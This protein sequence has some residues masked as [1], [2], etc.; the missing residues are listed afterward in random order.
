[1]STTVKEMKAHLWQVLWHYNEQCKRTQCSSFEDFSDCFDEVVEAL[2]VLKVL[3]ERITGKLS[4]HDLKA[5]YATQTTYLQLLSNWAGK[6]EHHH[7]AHIWNAL[8]TTVHFSL[9]MV[10][11]PPSGQNVTVNPQQFFDNPQRYVDD[12]QSSLSMAEHLFIARWYEQYTGCEQELRLLSTALKERFASWKDKWLE[13]SILRDC[14]V[15]GGV[16]KYLE[17]A[18]PVVV[19]RCTA[20]D[21]TLAWDRATFV[22]HQLEEDIARSRVYSHLSVGSV[23]DR[24]S[25]QKFSRPELHWALRLLAMEYVAATD[26]LLYHVGLDYA[27][28]TGKLVEIVFGRFDTQ[29]GYLLCVEDRLY[30][31][32]QRVGRDVSEMEVRHRWDV[33]ERL[34]QRLAGN[35]AGAPNSVLSNVHYNTEWFFG[36]PPKDEA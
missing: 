28:R 1:M 24:L 34:N 4:T 36:I 5:N 7:L 33:V 22:C 21:G 11:Y 2:D 23:R 16:R 32:G 29:D 20:L 19:A 8:V 3:S 9:A 35:R 31:F 25:L 15:T 26:N 10:N 13:H 17:E 30:S 18:F 27:L 6:I 12:E 14:D